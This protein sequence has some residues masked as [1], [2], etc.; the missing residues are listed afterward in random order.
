MQIQ[1]LSVGMVGTQCYILGE[2]GGSSCLVIDPGAEA[3]RIR[4]AGIQIRRVLR[5]EQLVRI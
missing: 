3:A 5:G 1:T 2:D 4:R